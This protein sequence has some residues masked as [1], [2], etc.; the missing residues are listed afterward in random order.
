MFSLN[1]DYKLRDRIIFGK[2][3]DWQPASYK[4]GKAAPPPAGIKYFILLDVFRLEKLV[5]LKLIDLNQAQN[6][7]PTVARFF[8]FMKKY[9]MTAAHGYAVSPN[10]DDYRV[11]IEGIQC[12]SPLGLIPKKYMNIFNSFCM[13]SFSFPDEIILDRFECYSWWD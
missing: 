6:L 3:I 11:S 12:Y 2:E 13:T 10:R 4:K 9:P 8:K 5:E 1:K 7:S